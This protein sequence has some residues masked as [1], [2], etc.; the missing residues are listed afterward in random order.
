MGALLVRARAQKAGVPLCLLNQ[1]YKLR[2]TLMTVT[3][4]E[5]QLQM[6]KIKLHA[7]LMMLMEDVHQ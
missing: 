2:L 3:I 6:L 5:Q 1:L 4:T 7:M